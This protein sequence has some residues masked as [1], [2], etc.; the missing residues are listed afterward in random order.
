MATPSSAQGRAR[1]GAWVAAA[2]GSLGL[3]ALGRAAIAS[4]A[5]GGAL[6]WAAAAVYAAVMGVVLW[7]VSRHHPHGT[8]GAA[9]QVTVARVVFIALVAGAALEPPNAALAW[10]VIALTSVATVLDGVGGWLARR[11]SLHSPF[12]ARF[13]MEVDALLTLAL[14]V[15]V[16]RFG[17]AGA[18]ILG[19]GLMR[20]AFV[21]MSWGWPWLRGPLSPT[22]RG[23]TVAVLQ[24][25]GL[26]VALAPPVRPGP[27]RV[28]AAATLATLVWS[29]AVDVRRLYD[30]AR[31]RP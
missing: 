12:G 29:F 31:N 11:A 26:G 15:L 23:K 25:I 9:N 17:K 20:Y 7:S 16:W 13:D 1:A 6:L 14:S 24:F 28:I 2:I 3:V 19:C 10:W 22:I 8:F 21:A 30:T 4:G 18:W 5:A 27:S